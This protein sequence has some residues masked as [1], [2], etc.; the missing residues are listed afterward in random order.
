MGQGSIRVETNR[1]NRG[2]TMNNACEKGW[3]VLTEDAQTW[4]DKG[5]DILA[6]Q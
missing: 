6:Q 5:Q 1:R 4:S 2:K 3:V